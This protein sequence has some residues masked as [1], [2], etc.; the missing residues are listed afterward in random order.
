M[1]GCLFRIAFVSLFETSAKMECNKEEALKAKSIAENK[2][3]EKDIVGAKKFA[4]K[5]QSLSEVPTS[6]TYDSKLSTFWTICNAC[7]TQFE[8]LRVFLNHTLLCQNC[9]QPFF[10]LS[11]PPPPLNAYGQPPT[12]TS[13][14]PRQNST[15]DANVQNSYP[16]TSSATEFCRVGS[17]YATKGDVLQKKMCV[18]VHGFDSFGFS[19]GNLAAGSWYTAASY[20]CDGMRELS[21][22]ELSHMLLEKATKSICQKLQE[23]SSIAA[24]SRTAGK[25]IRKKGKRMQK[26]AAKGMKTY[27]TESPE[28]VKAKIR[29]NYDKSSPAS[30]YDDQ[31]IKR[32]NPL[33]TIVLDPDFHDFDKDRCERSFCENQVWAAYD[34]DDSMPRYYAMIRKVISLKP[35]KVLISWLNPK[36]DPKLGPLNWIDS[37][38][39]QTTGDFRMEEP[40]VYGDLNSF[41]H[42]VKWD[43]GAGGAV[44]IYPRKGDVWALYRNW[45]PDWNEFTPDEV[46]HEYDLV[47]V[48]EDFIEKSGM[49]IAPLVKVPG[50]KTVFRRDSRATTVPV[51]QM[52][53]FSH[54]VPSFLLTG[55]E[56]HGAPEGCLELDPASLPLEQ[57]TEAIAESK[58]GENDVHGA[59][60]FALKAQSLYPALDGIQQFIQTLNVH[61]S[62][63]KRVNGVVDWYSVLGVDPMCDDDTIRK[64]YRR[65]LLTLHPD[66][67]KSV[68][69]DGAFRLLSEAWSLLSDRSK[70]VAYDQNRIS[71]GID[72]KVPNRKPHVPTTQNG[73]HNLSNYNNSS[74]RVLN[75]TMHPRRAPSP[76]IS[77]LNTF[78]TICSACKTQF[79]Y[80]RSYLNHNLLCQNCRQPFYASETP[81]PSMN[82]NCIPRMW[83]PCM[84]A[85]NTTGHTRDE[86]LQTASLAPEAELLK[87]KREESL[88]TAVGVDP[89][90]RQTKAG[91]GSAAGSSGAGL[92]SELKGETLMKKR[93]GDGRMPIELLYQKCNFEAG[94]GNI[95]GNPK[96]DGTRELSPLE[97]RSM[98]VVKAKKDIFGKLKIWRST[99]SLSKCLEKEMENGE[100]GKQKAAVNDTESYEDRRPEF[101]HMKARAVSILSSPVNPPDDPNMK[102]IDSRSMSVPDPDFHD[103]DKDRSEKSFGDNQIWAAYDDD[104]GMPR[105][106]ALIHS[107]ISLKPFK[108]RISWLNSKSNHEFG[109]LN[110]IGA[111]FYKTSG[112]FWIGKRE[113]NNT[114]NS[115]SHKVGKW[116]KGTRGAVHIYPAK[117]NVWALYRNWS[118]QWNAL[119]PDDVIHKYDMVE[120][121]EDYSEERGVSVAPLVKV[122]GFK[123]VFCRNPDTSKMRIVPR[124]E[125]FRFSHQVPSFV[126][127]GEEGCNAP[128]GCWELDPASTPMELLQVLTES[129]L[130]EMEMA[131][132]VKKKDLSGDVKNPTEEQLGKNY[133]MTK[134]KGVVEDATVKDA[135]NERNTKGK[136][137]KEDKLLM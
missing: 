77:K 40:S 131:G 72:I 37:G 94:R 88:A 100:Q 95:S 122:A 51:E 78:W 121:L 38:F 101:A 86:K 116:T 96:F 126:L 137:T 3:K 46:I 67:N 29:A 43:A 97:L 52:L 107:V 59:I 93:R 117:G 115:F 82:G 105:Y 66:K 130:K 103:F 39:Y 7:Q 19:K 70:R 98:L 87:R 23:F 129:Q 69:A 34:N 21:K 26:A 109:P 28:V 65:L 111:G 57:Y 125:M 81:P 83:P 62:A 11:I 1:A 68:G 89:F 47:E 6:P 58:F 108:V 50:F 18:D 24:L 73:F 120:I 113:V 90:L 42:K 132:N 79:E 102:V 32:D 27:A 35:F 8:Y 112:D 119:T 61:L 99:A 45:S 136:E 5:A 63:Q 36:V 4:T 17:S 44:G 128:K 118:P 53:R 49:P 91:L 2:F 124:E 127:T 22:L 20:T 15:C 16:A 134:G 10:A 80:L 30:S 33:F 84:Q 14:F 133:V 106:Y 55:P 41:S 85:S 31:D 110:W 12:Q 104:D 76:Y 114:I 13:Y 60:R 48:L 75:S 25:D 64:H 74:S 123:T 56:S 9:H 92:V 135:A 54:Q 71:K